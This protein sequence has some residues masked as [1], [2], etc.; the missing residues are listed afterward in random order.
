MQA[1]LDATT[2]ER[3]LFLA[4]PSFEPAD[5]VWGLVDAAI[6]ASGAADGV[7]VPG[8]KAVAVTKILHRKRPNL[9]PIFDS[10]IYRFYFGTLPVVG[11]YRDPPR[12]LWPVLQSDLRK[13]KA[14]IAEL[15]SSSRTPDG[16]GVSVLRAADIII[17]EHQTTGCVKA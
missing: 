10:Q 5:G 17:W 12:Q 8:L 9:V 1:V 3:P 16:R 4:V 15:S 6:V 13:N 11:A 2:I 7:G 14:W